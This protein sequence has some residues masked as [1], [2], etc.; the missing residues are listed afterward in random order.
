MLGQADKAPVPLDQPPPEL[1][2]Q[3]MEPCRKR[4]LRN[5]AGRRRL[6]EVLLAGK[7]HEIAQ[8]AQLHSLANSSERNCLSHLARVR[9][10]AVLAM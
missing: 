4:R 1:G 10:P 7:R 5:A 3:R 2:L 6:G 8:V 9:Q